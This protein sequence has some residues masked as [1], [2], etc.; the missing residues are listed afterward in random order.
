MP[1][2]GKDDTEAVLQEKIE[3]VKAK[4]HHEMEMHFD[5]ANFAPKFQE[6]IDDY[7]H[8]VGLYKEILAHAET[9]DAL[10][11]MIAGSLMYLIRQ[12]DLVPDHLKPLGLIDDA[13]VMRVTA[14]LAAEHTAELDPKFMKAMFKLANDAETV[15]EFL[16][17]GY[18]DLENYVRHQPDQ[19]VH[20]ITGDGVVEHESMLKELLTQVDEEMKNFEAGAIEDGAHVERELL[21]YIHLK[22]NKK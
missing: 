15:K 10:R 11:R 21:S 13:M 16:G 14:D 2:S 5:E 12:F 6:W 19:P 4:A 22:L 8:N 3:E 20:G 18:R 9:P 7:E 17:D 1:D